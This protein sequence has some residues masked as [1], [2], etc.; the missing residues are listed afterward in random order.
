MDGQG[1]DSLGTSRLGRP[2]PRLACSGSPRKQRQRGAAAA[3][4]QLQLQAMEKNET[5]VHLQGTGLKDRKLNLVRG[6]R[7]RVSVH[8]E[9]KESRGGKA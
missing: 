3:S 4:R 7:G 5:Q 6:Q 9:P 1:W 8:G 2:A